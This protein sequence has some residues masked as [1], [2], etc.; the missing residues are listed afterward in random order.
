[1]G[2]VKAFA[3]V[4]QNKDL[5]PGQPRSL[6]F[7]HR[8][9]KGLP[10]GAEE[11]NAEC[12][13]CGKHCLKVASAKWH[14]FY[15]GASGSTRG[16]RLTPEQHAAERE[17]REEKRAADSERALKIWDQC[18]SIGSNATVATYLEARRLDLPPDP[19]RVMRWHGACPFG[20]GVKAPCIVSLFRCATTDKATAI[21][22]TWIVSASTGKSKALGPIAGSAIKLWPLQKKHKRIRKEL[23]KISRSKVA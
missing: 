18:I 10:W 4:C 9:E 14:C 15:C 6:D 16:T 19:D 23:E 7:F 1:M 2:A 12:P 5:D 17:L 13:E 3:A 22:R 11:Q 21:H 20:P 8:D